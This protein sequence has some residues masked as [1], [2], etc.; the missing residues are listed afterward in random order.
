MKP[1]FVLRSPFFFDA[2]K[3]RRKPIEKVMKP[4]VINAFTRSFSSKK[5]A[6]NPGNNWAALNNI[7]RVP[8]ILVV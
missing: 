7:R 5:Y 3:K 1:S 8:K 6:R 4:V 2:K